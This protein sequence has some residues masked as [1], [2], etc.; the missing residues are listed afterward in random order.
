MSYAQQNSIM[1]WNEVNTQFQ[2]LPGTAQRLPNGVIILAN[3]HFNSYYA[4]QYLTLVKV[5]E[6]N[7]QTLL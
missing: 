3:L 5:N 2:D 1:A 7:R 6:I 4:K